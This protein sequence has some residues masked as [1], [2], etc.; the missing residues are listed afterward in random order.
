MTWLFVVFSVHPFLTKS[1]FRHPST[2]HYILCTI[3]KNT[4]RF[5]QTK[6]KTRNVIIMLCAV[7]NFNITH[8][9]GNLI[10]IYLFLQSLLTNWVQT[11]YGTQVS[12]LLPKTVSI[13]TAHVLPTVVSILHARLQHLLFNRHVLYVSV[14]C[15][16]TMYNGY[17]SEYTTFSFIRNKF[18]K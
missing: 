16:I 8:Y 18:S 13:L 3:V 12:C 9:S 6:K 10:V 14:L 11:K 17:Q 2:Y 4:S 1:S 5:F 15:N 7:F